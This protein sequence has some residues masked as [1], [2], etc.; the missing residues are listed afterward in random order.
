MEQQL[1]SDSDRAF[2]SKL[3]NLDFGP[4]A[5]KLMY[6]EEG[7]GLTKE[8]A[9]KAINKYR[10]FLF[11]SYLYP[12]E[13]IVPT[14]EIDRVWHTHILDTA[15]YREDCQVLFGYFMDHFP[16]FGTRSEADREQLENAFDRTKSLFDKHFGADAL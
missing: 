6:P 16:Y 3:Q 9:T 8:Q 7:Q 10:K 4:I 15:K 12:L 11:L 13:Q 1:L 5:F 2:L 14:P